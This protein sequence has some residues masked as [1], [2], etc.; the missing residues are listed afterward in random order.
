MAYKHFDATKPD[1]TTQNGTQV[2]QSIRDNQAAESDMI[3][4]GVVPGWSMTKPPGETPATLTYTKGL[5]RRRISLTWGTTGGE[6]GNVTQS[7]Y[8]A[9]YDGGS[10]YSLIGTRSFTYDANGDV[11]SIT[12]S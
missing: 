1:S 9:S 5:E 3:L 12:W 8:E 4:L 11:T 6:V 2:V 10:T 7:V